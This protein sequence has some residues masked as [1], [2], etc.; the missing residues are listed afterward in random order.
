V[1]TSPTLVPMQPAEAGLH[2][3]PGMDE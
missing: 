2:I 1:D 3:F